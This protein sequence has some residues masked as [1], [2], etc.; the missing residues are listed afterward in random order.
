MGQ[1]WLTRDSSATARSMR[2]VVLRRNYD[3]EDRGLALGRYNF[4]S[5]KDEDRD[6]DTDN[7]KD[8]DKDKSALPRQAEGRRRR[9]RKQIQRLRKEERKAKASRGAHLAY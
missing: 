4:I 5:N 9:T 6:K 8:K 1:G 2:T 7:D 3:Y